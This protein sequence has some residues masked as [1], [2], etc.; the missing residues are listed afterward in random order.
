MRVLAEALSSH[1]MESIFWQLDP[2]VGGS[3]RTSLLEYAET[4][5]VYAEFLRLLVLVADL[6]TSKDAE[7][8]AKVPLGQRFAG[9]V[10][11]VLV[12]ALS[13]PYVAPEPQTR[14]HL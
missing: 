2:A 10:R 13:T 4:E 9:F 12:P 5:L 14:K 6:G 1:C 3:E 7:L 11:H 8:S